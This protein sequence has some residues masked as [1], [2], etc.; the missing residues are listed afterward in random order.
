MRGQG[1]VAAEKRILVFDSGLGGLTVARALRKLAPAGVRIDYAADFAGFPYGDWEE[2]A[3]RE[4]L[5]ALM[6]RLIDQA[7]PDV[8]VIACNTASTLALEE[9]R[10][11]FW[12]LPF[13]GTV[14]AIKPAALETRS[15]IIGVLATPGTVRREYTEK[16]IHTFAMHCRVVLHGTSRLAALA[17][18]K[19]RGGAVDFSR[20][21]EE[22]A[23]AFV[24]GADGARTDVVVLGCTH[25]PLL[26]PELEEAAPW[27][28]KFIDPADAIA[29]QALRVAG[30]DVHGGRTR[31]N[32]VEQDAGRAESTCGI[33]LLTQAP[34]TDLHDLLGREGF[35][36]IV[37]AGDI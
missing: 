2:G 6:R 11:N 7:R 9:L 31:A 10:K 36:D 18:E 12:P 27:P 8:V 3:L 37:N 5:V 26:L 20:L 28:I 35:A 33:A 24:V 1:A 30:L 19:L 16:L 13:V 25:Y 15:R 34:D 17:E 32:V 14:P 4:H 22:I 21:R 23:P 29:R